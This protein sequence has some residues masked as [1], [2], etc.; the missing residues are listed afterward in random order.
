[1]TIPRFLATLVM[2]SCLLAAHPIARGEQI[3]ALHQGANR[4]DDPGGENWISGYGANGSVTGAIPS[5]GVTP[6]GFVQPVMN[7]HGLNAWQVTDNSSNGSL[8]YGTF[9]TQSQIQAVTAQGWTLDATLRAEDLS[10]E[11]SA[12]I[13]LGFQSATARWVLWFDTNASGDLQIHLDNPAAAPLFTAQDDG[14]QSIEWIDN[15]ATGASLSVDGTTVLSGYMGASDLTP[16]I[17]DGV[18]F[19]G[20]S[21][22]GEGTGYF[23]EVLFETPSVP[24]PG[25][26]TMLAVGLISLWI[27][28]DRNR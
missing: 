16:L 4:P 5:N 3:L 8:A 22:P 6:Y 15:P 13:Y 26:L 11:S 20:G 25:S 19:G 12:S 14:Y 17:D 24:E 28:R 18:T 23:N 9:F 21:S 7:D 27:M 1:V 2:T 10:T